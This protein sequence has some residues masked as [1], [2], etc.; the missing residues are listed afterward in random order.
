[1][2]RRVDV[3]YFISNCHKV[4]SKSLASNSLVWL[5]LPNLIGPLSSARDQTHRKR[6]TNNPK[7]GTVYLPFIISFFFSQSHLISFTSTSHKQ[8]L[9]YKK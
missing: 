7:W 8:R 3:E 9:I 1:M 2:V 4:L 6:K 5:F